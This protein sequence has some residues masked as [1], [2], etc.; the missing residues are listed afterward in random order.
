MDKIIMG[1][2]AIFLA[3]AIAATQYLALTSTLNYVWAVIALVWGVM[4]LR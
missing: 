3:V 4:T 2:G 1:G